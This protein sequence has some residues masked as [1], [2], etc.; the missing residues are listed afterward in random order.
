MHVAKWYCSV[1]TYNGH[2]YVSMQSFNT[3]LYD[4]CQF[5]VTGLKW[6]VCYKTF[7]ELN[8]HEA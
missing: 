8:L 5:N 1:G 6:L 3:D 7:Y 4:A 2:L